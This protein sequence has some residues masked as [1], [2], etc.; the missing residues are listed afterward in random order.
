MVKRKLQERV[1]YKSEVSKGQLRNA[2]FQRV[3]ADILVLCM[4]VWINWIA[5]KNG[6]ILKFKY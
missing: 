3:K 2:K 4:Y 1:Q 5:K 6:I